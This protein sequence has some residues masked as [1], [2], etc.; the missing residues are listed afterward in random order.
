[1]AGEKRGKQGR[2]K[3]GKKVERRWKEGGKK[4]ERRWKKRGKKE[5]VLG[6]GLEPPRPCGHQHLKLT[7]L[8]FRHPSRDLG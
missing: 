3:G 7:R 4:V 1:V 5:I 8:P 2:K 6:R